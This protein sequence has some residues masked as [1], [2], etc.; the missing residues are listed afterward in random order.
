[1]AKKGK[2]LS[3]LHDDEDTLLEVRDSNG[4]LLQ[5]GDSVIAIK[6]LKVKGASDIK[7]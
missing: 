6:D 7:R 4:N 3:W 2:D 1:M 5:N